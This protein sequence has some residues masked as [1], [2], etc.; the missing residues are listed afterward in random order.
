[1][2][3]SVVS[4]C[5]VIVSFYLDDSSPPC[6]SLTSPSGKRRRP[7]LSGLSSILEM[8]VSKISGFFALSRRASLS[9]AHARHSANVCCAES[10][11]ASQ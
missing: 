2:S 5:D 9:L 7:I 8:T 4:V 10:V 11:A 1:M 6:L 3:V